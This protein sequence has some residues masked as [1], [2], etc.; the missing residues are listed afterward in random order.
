MEDPEK[1]GKLLKKCVKD[2]GS[3][4]VLN[5]INLYILF[6]VNLYKQTNRLIR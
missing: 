1:F 2:M 4:G 3:D 6:K 5:F